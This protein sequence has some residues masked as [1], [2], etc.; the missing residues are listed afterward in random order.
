MLV[1]YFRFDAETALWAAVAILIAVAV[2]F[3]ALMVQVLGEQREIRNRLDRERDRIDA[4]IESVRDELKAADIKKRNFPQ[5]ETEK[6][7]G[8]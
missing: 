7:F 8:A 4:K 3:I 5:T 1:A 6:T 2:T